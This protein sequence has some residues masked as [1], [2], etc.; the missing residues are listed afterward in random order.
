[1]VG[2]VEHCDYYSLTT[3]KWVVSGISLLATVLGLQFF[4]G[5]CAI[6]RLVKELLTFL[7]EDDVEEQ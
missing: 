7:R 4:D 6:L 1:M 5:R 2:Q 3:V